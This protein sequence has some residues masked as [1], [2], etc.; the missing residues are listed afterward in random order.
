MR[1]I[2]ETFLE[3]I[4]DRIGMNY[5]KLNAVSYEETCPCKLSYQVKKTTANKQMIFPWQ[6]ANTIG[7]WIYSKTSRYRNL[8]NG[9]IF[10]NSKHSSWIL[11]ILC[12][13]ISQST[14]QT[15]DTE[16]SKNFISSHIILISEI[17]TFTFALV[18]NIQ[19]AF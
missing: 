14:R 12:K 9:D 17:Y 7:K 1:V 15:P 8:Q 3:Y 4:P 2:Y 18:V 13:I 19:S 10:A 11:K 16:K 5:R 6:F